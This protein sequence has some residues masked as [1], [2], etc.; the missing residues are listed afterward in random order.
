MNAL[1]IMKSLI[2]DSTVS[3][4]VLRFYLNSASNI[5]CDL[6]N[7]NMVE[8]KYV[9][10][11]V[12]IAMELYSKQG[13]EGQTAHS[14]NGISRTY[15]ASDVSPSLLSKITPVVKT[16]YSTVRIVDI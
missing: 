5:I 16:P 10:L 14:E 7:T 11:Q 13:A 12:R 9:N 8:N 3:D 4:T 2:N 15:E 1:D 6:R